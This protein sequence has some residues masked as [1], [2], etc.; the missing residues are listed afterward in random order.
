MN[1]GFLFLAA[2]GEG[3][4]TTPEAFAHLYGIE[5]SF[6]TLGVTDQCFDGALEI[7]FMPEG[8]DN[9]HEFEYPIYMP[10]LEETPYQ[11]SVDFR[12]PFVGMDIEIVGDETGQLSIEGAVMRA[13][14]LGGSFG[15]CAADMTVAADFTPFENGFSGVANIQLS[16]LQSTEE[17][18]PVP[19]SESCEVRLQLIT[20]PSE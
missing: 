13:V 12:E 11:G 15:D 1:M 10:L 7:L 2:C 5:H 9:P 19:S 14:A 4:L 3:K 16:N 20:E 18:C 17:A 6:Q 8:S